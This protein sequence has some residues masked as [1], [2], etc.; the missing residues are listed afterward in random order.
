M[1]NKIVIAGGG[2]TYTP[3]ILIGLIKTIKTFPVKEI[4]LY[5]IDLNRLQ[6]MGGF[7]QVL[8]REYLPSVNLVATKDKELAF[9]NSDFV[10]C[11]I[12]TGGM[13]QRELD[14]KIPLKHDSI[15]QETCGAGG[16][17]YGL[18]SIKDMI[19]LVKDIRR[20]SKNAWIINYS[21]PA[22]LVS[23]ALDKAYPKDK[24]ILNIC[25][26]PISLLQ[27]YSRLLG[28]TNYKDLVPYYFG[29]NHFGWFTKIINSKTNEDVTQTIKDK[30]KNDGFYPADKETRDASW[31]V[32]YNMVK[33]MLIYD[34]TYLPSTYLQYYL[35]PLEVIKT[36]NKDYTRA[37]EV[38]NGREKNVFMMCKSVIQK[39]ST[40]GVKFVE[41]EMN[42][43][44]GHG[45]TIIDIAK[46]IYH[47][48]N[49]PYIVIVKNKNIIKNFSHDA[50]VEVLCTLG[51]NGPKAVESLDIS[52]YY[53][54]L[55]ENQY[56]YELLTVESY[57]EGSYKKALQ[58]LTLNRMVNDQHKA[59]V[60][61]DDLIKANK[62]FFV[63]MK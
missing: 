60:I 39:N 11:Q 56:A 58:A 55:M 37:N 32:T 33:D 1:L 19:E 49:R 2:S 22:A 46:S 12:R 16:F 42:K 4:V 35:L 27:A 6:P 15:G 10:F 47:N 38:M 48:Q 31:L 51:K 3:G 21:N 54:G 24:R 45:E 43:T 9:K 40:K 63:E 53:K 23:I 34:D 26:Q 59:K 61:L 25:D 5:D 30:I 7:A 20:Y 57:F 41:D 50:M 18:R 36:L 17:A 14:E 52:P 29:L 62:A 13:K 28:N 8:F 44:N